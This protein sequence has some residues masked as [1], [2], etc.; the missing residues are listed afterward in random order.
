MLIWTVCRSSSLCASA[1]TMEITCACLAINAY[2]CQRVRSPETATL[3]RTGRHAYVPL[4]LWT[5]ASVK[6]A[7]WNIDR[8]LWSGTTLVTLKI[9]IFQ[10]WNEVKALKVKL[11]CYQNVSWGQFVK[12][13]GIKWCLKLEVVKKAWNCCDNTDVAWNVCPL[14]ELRKTI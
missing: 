1:N 7:Y 3:G 10:W 9:W 6:S 11:C 14:E 13:N 4:E 8:K 12:R 2:T 5:R